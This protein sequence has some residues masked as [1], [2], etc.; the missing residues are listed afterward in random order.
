M[1]RGRLRLPQSL[2]VSGSPGHDGPF[3]KSTQSKRRADP[4]ASQNHPGHSP[5]ADQ[6]P[7][8]N[9]GAREHHNRAVEQISRIA[10]QAQQANQGGQA[11]SIGWAGLAAR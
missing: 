6:M 4:H 10:C 8:Q 2:Q 7:P 3:G 1:R 9:Q 5:V 11:A